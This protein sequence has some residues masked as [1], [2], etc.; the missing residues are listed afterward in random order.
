MAM[1]PIA[2]FREYSCE[3]SK[4]CVCQL[5]H[6]GWFLSVGWRPHRPPVVFAGPQW[7]GHGKGMG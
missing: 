5:V 6:P 3:S 2:Y 4:R 1:F 7:I